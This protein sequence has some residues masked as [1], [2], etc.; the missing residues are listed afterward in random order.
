MF[1]KIV[2]LFKGER[3]KGIVDKGEETCKD[4]PLVISEPIASFL[5]ILKKDRS[6]FNL[7]VVR[8]IDMKASTTYVY[9]LVDTLE[10]LSYLF[11]SQKYVSG[12]VDF[13]TYSSGQSKYVQQEDYHE[14]F[15][16]LSENEWVFFSK[17]KIEDISWISRDERTL[18]SKTLEDYIERLSSFREKLHIRKVKRSYR[19]T[20]ETFKKIYNTKN[21]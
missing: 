7:Q 12:N 17:I 5:E 8:Y 16:Y 6:R 3:Q 10:K 1:N 13:I 9:L 11:A 4:V 18:L 14:G 19:K 15:P 20:R 21:I 2:N